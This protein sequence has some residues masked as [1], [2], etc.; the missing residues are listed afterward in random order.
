MVAKQQIA[1]NLGTAVAITVT[2][3]TDQNG[4][5]L[6]DSTTTVSVTAYPQ[7]SRDQALSIP[8]FTYTGTPGSFSSTVY[9]QTLS[10]NN[11]PVTVYPQV[12][13]LSGTNLRA[14]QPFA[15]NPPYRV[16]GAYTPNVPLRVTLS[17]YTVRG[18]LA[19]NATATGT[20][21]TTDQRG[22]QLDSGSLVYD[23]TSGAWLYD[24]PGTALPSGGNLHIALRMTDL[25]GNQIFGWDGAYRGTW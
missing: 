10:T 2:G 17:T 3:L 11:V 23:L 12:F 24:I 21:T 8:A 7:P 22:V 4:V 6:D 15:I 5:L 25:G 14:Q 13:D 19:T 9:G 16:S 18:V 1:A 20:V